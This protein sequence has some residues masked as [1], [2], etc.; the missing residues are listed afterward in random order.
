MDISLLKEICRAECEAISNLPSSSKGKIVKRGASGDITKMIDK[1]AEEAAVR[2]LQELGFEGSLLSEELG[3]V[4]I[5]GENYPLV[6]LDPIDGTTNAIRGINLYSISVALSDGPRLSDIVSAAVMELPSKRLFSAEKGAGAFLDGTRINTNGHVALSNAL[7]G[8]DFNVRGN[9]GR[10]YEVLP[11]LMAVKHIRNLGSAALGLCY[12]ASGSLDFYLDNRSLLRVTDIASAYLILKEAGAQVLA[13]DGS[14][15]DCPL[16]L[17]ARIE[18]IA[19]EEKICREV[20]SM[21]G[22]RNNRLNKL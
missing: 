11:V 3:L 15:L 19:G 18:L 5:G 2:C 8:V 21:I 10:V 17:T 22:S 12:T 20:L 9:R 4:K 16:D 1:V 7:V 14:E 13:L 6:V